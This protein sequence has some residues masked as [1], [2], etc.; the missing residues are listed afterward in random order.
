MIMQ[1]MHNGNGEW[2]L[3][4]DFEVSCPK[5]NKEPF[6]CRQQ[7]RAL[8]I[9]SDLSSCRDIR[10][11]KRT[12]PLTLVFIKKY[13]YSISAMRRDL[14]ITPPF[15]RFHRQAQISILEILNVFLWLKLSPSLNLSK[16][17]CSAK[18][19]RKHP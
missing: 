9:T 10:H 16:I 2:I 18:V 14:C 8:C 5:K 15:A 4:G 19:S 6:S 13:T 7:R 1:L 11:R 3:K 12:Q 17:E